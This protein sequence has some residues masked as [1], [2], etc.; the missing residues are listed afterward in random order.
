M[1]HF[2]SPRKRLQ[3]VDDDRSND[4]LSQEMRVLKVFIL[5][6]L[7]SFN[8]FG[9]MSAIDYGFINSALRQV[10]K[11]DT[12]FFLLQDKSYVCHLNDNHFDLYLKELKG[13]IDSVSLKEIIRNS[14]ATTTTDFKFG[15]NLIDKGNG[16][17][18]ISE[19]MVDSLQRE[20]NFSKT[21][22]KRLFYT[23][24]MPVFDSKKEYAVVDF[25]GGTKLSEMQ[26]QKYLFAKI[27]KDGLFLPDLTVG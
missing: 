22:R 16:A 15:G 24:S 7:T 21:L 20:K 2:I 14:H 5:T 10:A 6:V 1:R 9:Q 13:Q 25:G 26:G 4:N 3:H 12:S 17:K 19:A 8:S 11:Y 27:K 23:C 18:L